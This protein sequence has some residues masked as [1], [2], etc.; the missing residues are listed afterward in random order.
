M[1]RHTGG[2]NLQDGVGVV[3]SQGLS[4]PNGAA[5]PAPGAWTHYNGQ[6]VAA[7]ETERCVADATFAYVMVVAAGA[8]VVSSAWAPRTK[9]TNR[10]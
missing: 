10:R 4:S 8:S 1:I 2:G 9:R 7:G 6:K 3:L 5:D